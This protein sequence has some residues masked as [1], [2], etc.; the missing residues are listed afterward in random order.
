MSTPVHK[1]HPVILKGRGALSNPVGRFEVVTRESI[2]D[3][4]TNDDT[5]EP[6]P[7][8]GIRTTVT[9]EHARSIISRNQSP[10]VF[11]EQSINPYRGCEHGCV[12]CYARPNHA[13]MGLSPGR[14]FETRLFAKPA[15]ARLLREELG[16]SAY[17][18]STIVLGTAT[19]AYQPVERDMC[20]TR[21]LIEVL[22]AC[23]HPLSIITKSSLVERDIDLLAPMARRGLAAVYVTVTTLDAELARLW[24]PR[25]AA[26]WRRLETVRRLA[27][28]GIPVGVMVAPIVPFLNEPEI[29]RI[30]VQAIAAGARSAHY[31]VLRLPLELREVFCEWLNAHFPDRAARVLARLADM[32]DTPREAAQTDAQKPC[33]LNDS[34]FHHRMRG[35]GHWADLIRLRFELAC[36]KNQLQRD[37]LNL[38]L[39]QFV[40]PSRSG[41]MALFGPGG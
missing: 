33:R 30:L 29:E 31:T 40:P 4:W 24:E 10:D 21:S 36:R 22:S 37:R 11:F 32:R 23:N 5:V 34:R 26:P 27:E 9:L 8:P 17:R 3:G 14:D 20:L 7:S 2:D 12:Y 35:Q 1:A 28:A 13:Y 19:D 15:A 6:S 18:C 25:A 16:H 39:S 38:D 41:Q